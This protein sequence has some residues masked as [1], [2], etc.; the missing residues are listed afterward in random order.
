[1]ERLK[2]RD[3]FN[4]SDDGHAASLLAL[5]E[6]NISRELTSRLLKKSLVSEI[7]V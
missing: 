3:R 2:H 4:K 6:I 7:G 1:M 5:R